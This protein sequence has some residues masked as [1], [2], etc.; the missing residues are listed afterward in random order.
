MSNFRQFYVAT[1]CLWTISFQFAGPW[2]KYKLRVHHGLWQ[3][4]RLYILNL[5]CPKIKSYRSVANSK[6]A[7]YCKNPLFPKRSQWINI[8]FSLHKQTGGML[9]NKTCYFS[10]LY[11][12]YQC[13]KLCYSAIS[14]YWHF[15]S[16]QILSLNRIMSLNLM[17]LCSKLKNGLCKIVTK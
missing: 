8:K 9:L 11:D 7:Y 15:W 10:W 13:N 12:F 6:L 2:A 3:V 5:N 16:L 4:S 14:I 1:I 17:I